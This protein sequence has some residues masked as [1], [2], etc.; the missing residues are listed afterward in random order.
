MKQVCEVCGKSYDNAKSLSNH[1]R[2]HKKG[3]TN[4]WLNS[5]KGKTG[6]EF[7]Q[8]QKKQM[9]V[10]KRIGVTNPDSSRQRARY[11]YGQLPCEVCGNN[12]EIHHVDGNPFN[13]DEE[14]IQHLCRKHHMEVDGRLEV[15]VSRNKKGRLAA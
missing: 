7:T 4:K 12:S 11:D 5:V 1:A 8:E 14:N 13:N 9:S 3:F 6:R 10:V 2:H 15:L